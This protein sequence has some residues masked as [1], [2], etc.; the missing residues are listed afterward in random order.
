MTSRPPARLALV[1]A[2]IVAAVVGACR[3]VP[4]AEGG[5]ASELDCAA[6]LVC[7]AGRCACTS[8]AA[9][10]V[11]ESCNSSGS[12]QR[13]VGCETSFDCEADQFCDRATGY[14]LDAIRCTNDVQCA[15]GQVC[16]TVA[17]TCV[18]GCRELGDCALGSV[19]T[20]ESGVQK[21]D[22]GLA[23]CPVDTETCALGSCQQ[24]PCADNSFCRYGESCRAPSEGAPRRCQRDDRGPFC[25]ACS[26]VPGQPYGTCGDD[27]RNFCLIDPSRTYRS[28]YCGV[29]CAADEDCPWGFGC[30]DVLV[31]T[32]QSCERSADGVSAVCPARADRPCAT[33]GDCPGGSC[34]IE[35][36]SCRPNCVI[37]EGD[38][39]GFCTCLGDDD[40][41]VDICYG[42]TCTVSRAACD[43]GH[44]CGRLFCKNVVSKRT[45]RAAGY[46]LVGRNCGPVEGVSCDEVNAADTGTVTP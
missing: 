7:I 44:P 29:N 22:A 42:G 41:P 32:Q 21:C 23:E 10:A 46:C 19:C 35:A 37:G 4:V 43:D 45:G 24:G 34:D 17:F 3:A 13:R 26:Y 8:D 27:P 15:L 40:C 1:F 5:C 18:D 36:K 20:C 6:G 30:A 16:D 2:S 14:C 39:S 31:L 11:G 33:D 9:C 12:C 38:S 28:N 25:E